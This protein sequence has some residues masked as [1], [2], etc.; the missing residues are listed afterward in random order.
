MM[1]LIDPD[2]PTEVQLARQERI[3][4]A[5][6]RRADRHNEMNLSAYGA[7]QSAIEL[8]AQVAAQSR[9]LEEAASEL[10]TVRGDRARTERDLHDALSVMPE[11][12]ALFTDG[13]LNV[14][15]QLFRTVLPDIA[16]EI[17]TGL[18]LDGYFELM[19]RSRHLV[20]TDHKIHHPASQLK[21]TPDGAMAMS[22]MI[23][24]AG[25]I[26]YQLGLQRTSPENV[27]LL[28]TEVTPIVR[29][30]RSEKKTLIDEQADYLQA[31]FETMTSGVCTFS[32]EGKVMMQNRQFRQLLGVPLAELQPGT[33]LARLLAYMQGNG[34]VRDAAFLEIANWQQQLTRDGWLR[35]VRHGRGRMLD[36]QVNGLPDGGF[37]VELKDVT[38]ESRAT[39]MLENR[40]LERTAELTRANARLTEQ[41]QEKA[42]VEEE[43]RVAKERAEAAVSSK[44]RFLAAASHDL[45]QPINAAKL[46]ISTLQEAAQDSHLL[47][48]V[49]R[50]HRAFS[51]TEQL[52][53]ALLDISRLSSADPDAVTPAEV[54]LGVL[55]EGVFADQLPLSEYR[56]V[57]LDVVPCHLVVWSDPV[58]LQRSIQ[59]LVVNAIQYTEAGGRVLLGARRRGDTVVLQVWDTGIG[60][61]HADQKRIFEEFARAENAGLGT[62]MGLGLSVVDRTCRH[63]GHAL[64]LRSAP[65]CGSVFSIEMERVG[66][67][68]VRIDP[69]TLVKGKGDTPFDH[70]VLVIENDAEVLFATRQRLSRWGARVLGVPSTQG[71]HRILH[72]AGLVPD[73]V[74]A[75]YHLDGDDTGLAAVAALRDATGHHLPAI[76]ITADRSENLRRMAAREDVSVISKPV[77]LS[78][79]RP[80]IDWAIQTHRGGAPER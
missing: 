31:V 59:N 8:Q 69:A 45:L 27:V 58:Y 19:V 35:R 20:S 44:T 65:G 51:S 80:L 13:R 15:N 24:L 68:G 4:A 37:L 22:L 40:V 79:L 54:H 52:L 9:D 46:L 3:I 26:W 76:L 6:M 71:A 30:N 50:L 66:D 16:D 7:F 12:F 17:V 38:L 14:C 47:P 33:T 28:L 34:L 48:M 32:P 43:L 74:L 77:K 72:Q 73:I 55:M 42:R 2:E 57:R 49:D 1:N 11:G 67:G 41:F 64:S 36:V 5:L 18:T 21:T 10:E 78:R 39:E 53:H 61:D 23:G 70:T 63:L 62:G 75:D 60:I 56:D 29:R 25:D